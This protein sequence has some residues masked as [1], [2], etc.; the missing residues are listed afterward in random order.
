[1]KATMIVNRP[2]SKRR[3][4]Q[5]QSVAKAI[6]ILRCFGHEHPTLSVTEISHR[7]DLHK[8]TVSR[9]LRTLEQGGLV[10][11]EER[12]GHYR[13]GLGLL[14]MAGL[15]MEGSNLRTLAQPHLRALAEASG[16]TANLAVL[17][18]ENVVNIDQILSPQTIKHVGWIGRRNPLHCT[19]GGRVFLAFGPEARVRRVLTQALPAY[20]P[21]TLT[22]PSRLVEELARVRQDGYAVAREEFETGLTAIAAPI[23]NGRDEVIATCS[24]SGPSFR[25][26]ADAIPVR[27]RQ[28]LQAA[29]RISQEAMVSGIAHVE[30]RYETRGWNHGQSLGAAD[31]A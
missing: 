23:R 27:V 31:T 11:C 19:S 15:V 18:R 14:E 4:T 16:E 3:G 2:N 5:I 25:F 7:L 26:S 9:L 8:S 13:L 30:G 22:D 10:T 29:A 24:V 20:T 1:M 17:D 28:V 12:T 21:A 6:D